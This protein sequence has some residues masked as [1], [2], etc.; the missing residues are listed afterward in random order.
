LAWVNWYD[1]E[2]NFHWLVLA[3]DVL[4]SLVEI[5]DL[6]LFPCV[7]FLHIIVQNSLLPVFIF[8]DLTNA[9]V[10]TLK[11]VVS[12]AGRSASVPSVVTLGLGLV[13]SGVVTFGLLC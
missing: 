2:V 5:Q 8:Q 12:R 9:R 1:F 6:K 3:N 4:L 10:H 11:R 13:V 7:L